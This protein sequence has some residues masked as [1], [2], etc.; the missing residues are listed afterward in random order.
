D[1]QRFRRL[2]DPSRQPLASPVGQGSRL[3]KKSLYAGT[4]YAPGFAESQHVGLF[5]HEEIAP[6]LP[7]LR[8]ADRTDHRRHAR[9]SIVRF[10]EAPGSG[11]FQPQQLLLALAL[12]DVLAD[13]AVS[14]ECAR[15][16]EDRLGAGVDP[17][18]P[19]FS[20]PAQLQVLERLVRLENCDMPR[21]VGRG[22][23]DVVELPAPLADQHPRS[24][25]LRSAWAAVGE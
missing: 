5:I 6:A 19:A 1:P 8:L 24:Q 23:V 2:P 20:L 12:G 16:V 9:R 21:P 17:Q 13:A 25:S 22:H 3:G 18:L 14:L 11:M 15:G 4:R 7:A 10:G